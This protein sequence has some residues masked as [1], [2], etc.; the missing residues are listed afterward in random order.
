M[1]GAMQAVTLISIGAGGFLGAC[2]RYLFGAWVVSR[3]GSGSPV[4]TL[5]VNFAG[6]LLLALFLGW[7]TRQSALAPQTRLLVSVGF[8]GAF[9]TFS[10]FA[11][12]SV[13]LAREG[14][15]LAAAGNILGNNLLCLGG[16]CLGLALASRL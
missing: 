8:C 4:G 15:L 16:V 9:T 7:S 12:E 14:H 10:T 3:L 13:T 6:S 5:A 11:F 2:A 1:L